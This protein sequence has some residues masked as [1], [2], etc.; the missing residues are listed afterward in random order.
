MRLQKVKTLI[1]EGKT[2]Q[3]I[4]LL[5]AI[6][7][8]KDNQLLNQTLLLEGQ[9]RD[10]QKKMQLGLQDAS[11]ELNRINFTLL[12]VCDDASSLPNIGDDA[13]EKPFT[14]DDKPTGLLANPLAIFGIL[15]AIAIAT[16]VGFVV[17]SKKSSPTPQ[18]PVESLPAITPSVVTPSVKIAAPTWIATPSSATISE[19]YY[20]NVKTDVLS[21]K[22]AEKD[23]N[24]QILTLEFKFNCLGST[25][26]SCILNYLEYRLL[27]PTGDKDAPSDDVFFANA[28]KIG[29]SMTN[30][31]SFVL[32]KNQTTADLQIYYRDK[33]ETTL[34]TIHLNA[35]QKQ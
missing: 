7:K 6:L 2:Q 16:I 31:I 35:L 34:T 24:S 8:D 19:K 17:F 15:T 32:P 1:S 30:K 27:S 28:P 22:T 13:D 18:P 21:I 10:L 12:S 9:Y 23:A 4:D 3:A 20:G 11:T 5:Q 33:K 26:G 25:S 29:T 14:D